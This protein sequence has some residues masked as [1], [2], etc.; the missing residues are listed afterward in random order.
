MTK[1]LEEEIK[2]LRRDYEILV[3]QTADICSFVR[4]HIK[5]LNGINL[6][7]M[8]RKL[9]LHGEMLQ[10][11][12]SEFDNLPAVVGSLLNEHRIQLR[13]LKQEQSNLSEHIERRIQAELRRRSLPQRLKRLYQRSWHKLK[14]FLRI[15]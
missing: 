10:R 8:D 1:K 9:D 14:N 7:M 6:V 11:Y 4:A 3:N 5:T 12:K 2:Q 13:D 15:A